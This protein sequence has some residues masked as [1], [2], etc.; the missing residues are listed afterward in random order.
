MIVLIEDPK[1]QFQQ[2][3]AWIVEQPGEVAVTGTGASPEEA[4][5]DLQATLQRLI[6][7]HYND[8]E[9]MELAEELVPWIMEDGIQVY[10]ESPLGMEL[11]F[12]NC[13]LPE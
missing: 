10:A 6:E 9:E 12:S 4:L 13:V 5:L 3:M 2:F 7:G 8:E 1:D 11:D